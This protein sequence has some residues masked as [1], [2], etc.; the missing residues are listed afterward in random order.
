MFPSRAGAR[1]LYPLF[2][3]RFLLTIAYDG[4]DFHGWQKQRATDGPSDGAPSGPD[5][6]RDG[7]TDGSVRSPAPGAGATAPIPAFSPSRV[8]RTVQEVVERAVREVVREPIELIGASRTDSGVHAR[9]QAA[10]FTRADLAREEDRRGPP[11]DRLALAINSRLPDDVQVTGARP[12]HRH[13]D[14]IG[15]CEAKGYRYL[16]H[17]AMERPLWNRRVVHHVHTPLDEAPMRDAAARLIGEHDFAAFAAAGHGR[18]STVRTVH[19]CEVSRLDETTL[20]IDVAGSGFLWN[21][22]RIIAGTLV[23]VGRGRLTLD[24]VASALESRD[25][26]NAGPTLPPTGL[27]L[28]WIRYPEA[29]FDLN[30]DLPMTRGRRPE[31]ADEE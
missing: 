8:L 26:R 30:A 31:A 3:A 19:Q 24:D 28:M 17:T 18:L 1:R 5:E 14:P 16:L 20:A 11:D 9:M 21:M 29:I 27:C 13:F 23:D 6:P 12:V 10:A 25:R 7:R 15:H 4:T 2:V 22:V